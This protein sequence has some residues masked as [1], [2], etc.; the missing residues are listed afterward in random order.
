MSLS[1]Q[2][3]GVCPI[4]VGRQFDLTTI[5]LLIDRLRSGQGQALLVSGEA[6]IGKSRLVAEAKASAAAYDIQLLQG[7]CFQTDRSSPYAPL[8]DLFRAYLTETSHGTGRP[9]PEALKPAVAELARL[10]PEISWLYPDL[11][12]EATAPAE[13][14]EQQK[15]RLFAM[16]THFFS[17]LATQRPLMVVVEDIHWSDDLSL[18]YLARLAR[19]CQQSPLLVLATYRA[20]ET[21][22]RLRQWLAELDRERLAQELTVERLTRSDV[23]AM[24]RAILGIAHDADP[25]LLAM[26]YTRSEGNPFFVEELL[27]SLLTTGELTLGEGGWRHTERR[28]AIPRSVHEAVQQRMAYLSADA[29]RLL[30]LASVAGRRF[31]V[32][33]LGAIMQSD[34]A[35]LLALLR[36]VMAAQ[37]VTEEA[38]DHFA[39]R[40]VLTQQAIAMDLLVRERQTLHRA[41]AE[42]LEQL[43]DAALAPERR[44]EE[45][46]YHCF[47]AGMWPQALA[48][49]RE[50]GERAV[51]LY[52]QQAAIDHFTRAIDAAHHLAQTPPAQVYA[53]RGHAYDTLGEFERARGDYERALD[54]AR[55]AEDGALQWESLLALG[56]LWSG[57]DYAQAGD[58]FRQALDLADQLADPMLRAHSLNRLGNW[59]VNTGRSEEGRQAHHEADALFE[60]RG[61]TRGMAE[62]LDLLGTAYGFYGDRP[63][64]DPYAAQ[65]IPL[66]RALGDAQ[67]LA[68]ILASRALQSTWETNETILHT[69]RTPEENL[70]DADESLRLARQ[71]GSLA[72]QAFAEVVLA[73][74]CSHGGEIG[75]A[76]AHIRE[77]QRLATAIEHRQWMTLATY[78]LGTHYLQ[79]LQP[80][81]ARAAFDAEAQ[82]ARE[83]GSD[84]WSGS[85]AAAQA[86]VALLEH[87]PRQ[88]A[89]ILSAFMPEDERPQTFSQRQVAWVWAQVALAQGA[90]ERALE[91]V[92]HLLATV[93]G[94]ASSQPIPHLL[95]LK[96][97]AL[98]ALARLDEAALT[99]A[100]AQRGAEL[101]RDPFI[102][103]RIHATAARLA[104]RGKDDIRVRAEAEAARAII[105]A[106]AATIDEPPLRQAFLVAALASLPQSKPRAAQRPAHSAAG[107]LSAREREVAT[108]VAQ[109]QTNREIAVQLVVSERTAEAH[110]S[111]ILGK[112]GFTTRAQ[113]A[114]W[115]VL[116]GLTTTA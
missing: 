80:A 20:D 16:M 96:A 31:N 76:L 32:A 56:F 103:W 4:F 47:E 116:H 1:P 86:E 93:P 105:E 73:L 14:S 61:D 85:L 57:R 25:E 83:L 108:L 88:A 38:A 17:E 100:A 55:Q 58:W 79:L 107:G 37:L 106:L 6:G 45:L 5:H 95:R 87:D 75:P 43:D 27:K 78:T 101:R 64:S 41:L 112:L 54:A 67:S 91:R 71:T 115:A 49:A 92:E 40:H 29:R 59:L 19:R 33:L 110:V 66:F 111:N 24:A 98:L 2:G 39:F 15:R 102:R 90:P 109:G 68:S 10:L 72:G 18:E 22:P 28:V 35:T 81:L 113:I 114:A 7:N 60:Q 104:Q 11:P 46:A 74:A 42:A 65:A 51:A 63:Q 3:T 89:A 48:C 12:R 52:A 13:D 82:L 70:R 84:L 36:E 97:E 34:E 99:L 21:H 50:A 9:L 62:S 94:D 44:L 30:T 69:L 53:A 77:A 26:L 23:A 8:L